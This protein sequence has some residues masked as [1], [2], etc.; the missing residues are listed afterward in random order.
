MPRRALTRKSCKVCSHPERHLIEQ[1]RV[2]GCSLDSIAAKFPGVLRDSIHRHMHTH[3]SEAAKAVYL[4]DIPIAEVAERAGREN[5]SILSYFALIRSTVFQQ[6]LL[7]SSVNDGNR[8]AVLAGRATE[9]L[10]E[11]GRVTGE[12]SAI[13]SLTVNN[14]NNSIAFVNSPQFARLES[15]LIDRL[16]DYPQ[17]LSAVVAGLRELEDTDEP[18]EAQRPPM[19]TLPKAR[20]FYV[21]AE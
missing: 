7:A 8:V 5:G 2:A 12:L 20:G 18:Q 6:L 15:M 21:A 10:R 3:V 13:G 11:I 14:I 9:V 19:I 4:A 1:L 16:R 17:A